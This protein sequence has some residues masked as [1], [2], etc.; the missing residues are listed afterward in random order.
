MG[1]SMS[2]KILFKPTDGTE[3]RYGDILYHPDRRRVGWYCKAEFEPGPHCDEVRVCSGSGAVSM[4]FISE[5]CKEPP[6]ERCRSCGQLLP[7][8][9]NG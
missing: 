8:V 4:V 1:T 2:D 7:V 5:L 6:I 9:R 3:V